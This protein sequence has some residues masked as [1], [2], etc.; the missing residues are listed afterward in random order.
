[1]RFS[2]AWSSIAQSGIQA[3]PWQWHG[4]CPKN[5]IG[6]ISDPSG[7]SDGIFSAFTFAMGAISAVTCTTSSLCASCATPGVCSAHQGG[8]QGLRLLHLGVRLNQIPFSWFVSQCSLHAPRSVAL[9]QPEP[10]ACSLQSARSLASLTIM[11][12][13]PRRPLPKRRELVRAGPL[14]GVC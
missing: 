6:C 12:N 10:C 2:Q 14:Y 5:V 11:K 13:L 4:W 1:M 9:F 3:D 7:A 8:L